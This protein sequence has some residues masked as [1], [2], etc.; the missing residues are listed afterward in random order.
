VLSPRRRAA[1]VAWARETDGLIIEDDYDAEFRYDKDPVSCVQG[2]APEHVA[3]TSSV[4]KTL[5]PGLRLGWVLAPQWLAAGLPAARALSDLGS[6]VT[7]QEAFARF[8]TSGAYDR[9]IRSMRRS[10]RSRRD[11]LIAALERHLP[12]LH[13]RGVSAGLHLYAELPPETDDAALVVAAA[14]RGVA[15]DAIAARGSAV[16]QGTSG[17]PGSAA[18]EPPALMLGY[19]ALPERALDEAAAL[20]AEALARVLVRECR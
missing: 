1:L 12:A 9:H 10:Y 7:N 8:I 2:L 17:A 19:A 11:A 6:P 5:A 16:A 14:R 13:V 20:L 3:L 15:V 4:S 18:P